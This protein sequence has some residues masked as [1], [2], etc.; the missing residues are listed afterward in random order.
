LSIFEDTY[1]GRK[2]I[3]KSHFQVVIKRKHFAYT[4]ELVKKWFEVVRLMSEAEI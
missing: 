2:D 1:A 3:Q 4:A